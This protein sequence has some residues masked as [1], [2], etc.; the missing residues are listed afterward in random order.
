[1][2]YQYFINH[3]YRIYFENREIL[4]NKE[5]F[6]AFLTTNYKKLEFYELLYNDVQG[7]IKKNFLIYLKHNWFF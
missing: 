3:F 6:K 4:K 1:M 7:N 5:Q 2:D